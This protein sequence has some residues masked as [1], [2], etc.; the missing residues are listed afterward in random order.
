MFVH[1]IHRAL[2]LLT[3]L[4]FWGVCRLDRRIYSALR[5][6]S[7]VTRILSRINMI[8]HGVSKD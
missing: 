4:A 5:P 1:G 7:A 3:C 8:I 6:D 2:A